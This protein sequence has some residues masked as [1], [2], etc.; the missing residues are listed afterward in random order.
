MMTEDIYNAMYT[1]SIQEPHAF[2]SNQ[3]KQLIHWE[4]TWEHV[5]VGDF[6]QHPQ[7]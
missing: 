4:Q 1:Q 7:Q 2:W 5:L 3:A 6:G